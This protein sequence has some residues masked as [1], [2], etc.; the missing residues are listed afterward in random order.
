MALTSCQQEIESQWGSKEKGF[1]LKVLVDEME[2][3]VK[4]RGIPSENGESKVNS[5]HLAF[6]SYK[7][8]GSGEYKG[9]Y[10]APGSLDMYSELNV[11]D[12]T[13]GDA[14]YDPDAN[15]SILA[16]ANLGDYV[17]G[18][19]DV[20]LAELKDKTEKFVLNG[21]FA[22]VTG[23]GVDEDDDTQAITPEEL[24]MSTRAVKMKDE[25][26]I[27]VNLKR[28]LSRF[29]VVNSQSERTL[30]SIS[31]WG[32]ASSTNIWEGTII[33]P[34][35]LQRFY[36]IKNIPGEEVKGG[37]YAFENLVIEPALGDT[38]TTCLIIGLKKDGKVTYY[39]ADVHPADEAQNL[40]RNF[41]YK[42]NI[43]AAIGDGANSEY[44]AWTQAKNLLHVTVNAWNLD[45]N[46]MILTDGTNT[47]GIP[48]KRVRL[49]SRGDI[50]EYS[51]YT[52]GNGTLQITKSDLDAGLKVEIVGNVLRVTGDPMG[53]PEDTR[54]GNIEISFAGLRGSV[55]IIQEKSNDKLLTL[56]RVIV[57]NFSPLGRNSMPEG[58]LTVTA[59]GTWTAEIINT[60]DDADNPGFSFNPSGT[61]VTI[62]KSSNNPYGDKFQIY[63]TGDNPYI[64]GEERSGFI[65][66]SLDEDPE[67][68]SIAVP[69]TQDK[70]PTFEILPVVSEIRFNPDG[71][72]ATPAIATGQIYEFTVNSSESWTA[73]LVGGDA[74]KFTLTTPTNRRF[75]IKANG[76]NAGTQ[77]TT[78]IKVANADNTKV[79]E[80]KVY[81]EAGSIKVTV[82]GQVPVAGGTVPVT[83]TAPEGMGWTAT[84]LNQWYTGHKAYINAKPD[85]T[86]NGIGSASFNVGFDKLYYPY[87]NM[88]PV[89]KVKV[90]L[91]T[92]PTVNQTVEVMQ[93]PFKPTSLK[94][95]DVLANSYGAL[96]GS[97]F[98]GYKNFI[99][100][101]ALFGPNGRVK[102][103][104]VSITYVRESAT[105]NPGTEN[106]EFRYL[107]A[108]GRPNRYSTDR[109]SKIEAWRTSN[110][111]IVV[112][113]CDERDDKPFNPGTTLGNCGYARGG[114]VSSPRINSGL[115]SNSDPVKKN[116]MRYLLQD[117]P[118]GAVN[119]PGSV[120][121]G[122]DG[123]SN[124]VSSYPDDAVP[125]IMGSNGQP[126]VV[127]DPKNKL[128]YM[129][130]SQLF[131]SGFSTS[132]R[133]DKDRFLGNLQAYILNAAQR[134][135]VF[136]DTFGDDTQYSNML[137][138]IYINE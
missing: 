127:I 113:T 87:A 25:S 58:P 119:S 71:S 14:T 31:I 125:V 16:F 115:L 15:Y 3:G 11:T 48:V 28:G 44:E 40:K 53:N 20:F 55:D 90:T 64:N 110:D 33:S 2:T 34:D 85:E 92:T 8:D 7:S 26:I 30:E 121:F 36:G 74:D 86:F 47:L 23:V 49:D 82:S 32:A 12:F 80:I 120:S 123:V 124:T 129:G 94:V 27:T 112:F 61:P 95:M 91:T 65:I 59:S 10:E 42:I 41:C 51:I 136:T 130:E 67:N 88:T 78:T 108:G 132:I 52:V 138:G 39:R 1:T 43:L 54:R 135:S 104:T 96:D 69:L 117:G 4:T 133:S 9:Y 66:V 56:D 45:D 5:L 128:I 83:V 100:S 102:L 29:D 72:P 81:Q 116:I 134:G 68:Y 75:V 17:E 118:F 101:S 122:S 97:Y 105:P 18:G 46:G 137:Q 106:S 24:F 35:H 103:P 21:M 70:K 114:T 63:T 76:A 62:L 99:K 84:I 50:R 79:Q 126:A 57:A 77:L 38:E 89:V 13:G 98:T 60:H 107:H 93:L 19:I 73:T 6:F 111:G 37:L 109:F 22:K 131:D